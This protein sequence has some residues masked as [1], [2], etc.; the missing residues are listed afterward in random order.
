MFIA[1]ATWPIVTA[2]QSQNAVTAYLSSKHLLFFGTAEWNASY[3]FV[4]TG[5]GLISRNQSF[6]IVHKRRGLAPYDVDLAPL[7]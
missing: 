4:T 2:V 5:G 7:W 6:F 1:L 3:C